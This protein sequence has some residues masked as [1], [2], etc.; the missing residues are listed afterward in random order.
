MGHSRLPL[1]SGRLSA[2]HRRRSCLIFPA[3]CTLYKHSE[4]LSALLPMLVHQRPPRSTRAGPPCSLSRA[5]PRLFAQRWVNL[6]RAP[7]AATLLLLLIFASP[8]KG[9]PPQAPQHPSSKV[10]CHRAPRPSRCS[11]IGPSR[12]HIQHDH[13]RTSSRPRSQSAPSVR[14]SANESESIA[15]A[16]SDGAWRALAVL[17]GIAASAL[18]RA[19][20][21]KTQPL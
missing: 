20:G 16:A 14:C 15:H 10:C 13:T 5:R 7:R 19:S 21:C 8:L 6:C 9:P 12:L 4:A 11:A 18:L 1:L 3:C 17:R 2:A